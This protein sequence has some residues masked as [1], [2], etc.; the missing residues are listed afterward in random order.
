[1]DFFNDVA[2]RLFS[3]AKSAKKSVSGIRLFFP[4]ANKAATAK[5]LS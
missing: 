3:V 1:V 4:G 5:P 2:N